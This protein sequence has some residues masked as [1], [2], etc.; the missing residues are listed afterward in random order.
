MERQEVDQEVLAPTVTTVQQYSQ[1]PLSTKNY[2]PPCFTL[3]SNASL[4]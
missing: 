4:V 1:Y 3:L 2:L